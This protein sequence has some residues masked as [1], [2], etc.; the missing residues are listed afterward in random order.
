MI[1][2]LIYA[3]NSAQIYRHQKTWHL[4][5]Y[6]ISMYRI[7]EFL[8]VALIIIKS[9]NSKI[10][11]FLITSI[12]V[13]NRWIRTVRWFIWSS[14]LFVSF[15]NQSFTSSSTTILLLL[16]FEGSNYF[17]GLINV[18]K[19][20]STCLVMKGFWYSK[21]IWTSNNYQTISRLGKWYFS[22][23]RWNYLHD[24]IAAVR[25]YMNWG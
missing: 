1:T 7:S 21:F 5:F 3:H 19:I 8:H 2:F 16:H 13:F 18:P 24:K 17:L 4:S 22:T 14:I 9:E 11:Y 23:S 6:L 10:S 20:K 15:K 12:D 25:P